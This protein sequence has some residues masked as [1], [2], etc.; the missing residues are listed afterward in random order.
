M[1]LTFRR[2]SL[3]AGVEPGPEGVGGPSVVMAEWNV[4][5]VPEA[6]VGPVIES[7]AEAEE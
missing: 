3:R 1:A 4:P 5:S 2:T 7:V 6:E